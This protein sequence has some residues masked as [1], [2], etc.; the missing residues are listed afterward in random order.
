MKPAIYAVTY[1]S[2]G[3]IYSRLLCV[4]SRIIP[5]QV[6]TVA[7]LELCA[8]LLAKLYR[9]TRRQDK[10]S[11]FGVTPPLCLDG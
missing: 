6:L 8:L 10:G 3:D 4:K 1:D 2:N 7:K 9:S 5:L 11:S